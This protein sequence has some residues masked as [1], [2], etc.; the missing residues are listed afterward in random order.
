MNK[1]LIIAIA[2]LSF[3]CQTKESL[4]SLS[5]HSEDDSLMVFAPELALKENTYKGSFS[6]DLNTFYFFRKDTA[7]NS[8]FIPYQSNFKDGKWSPA[9]VVS[10]YD[11]QYSYTFQLPIPGTDQLIIISNMRTANDSSDYPNYNFWSVTQ[12]GD[13]WSSPKE[14][15]ANRL[16]TNYNSQPSITHNGSIY[17]S[18]FTRDYRNQYPYKMEKVDGEYKEPKIFKPIEKVRNTSGW[19][20]GPFAM[21]PE[22][23][24]M[25]MTIKEDDNKNDDLY[26]SYSKDGEWT[27][28]SKLNNSINTL[29]KEG[30]PYLTPNG[31]Y[32]IFTRAKS[33][34]YIVPTKQLHM[35]S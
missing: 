32:L 31:K 19:K 8:N 9:E 16:V 27:D 2:F 14:F 17:F 21:D 20:V 24:F 6:D 22:E 28:P 34:F 26:I 11:K 12:S 15:G 7:G 25:I 23:K 4:N 30:F 1:L 13:Q 10:Y 3:S 33:Q 5:S 35:G 18:S 29:E